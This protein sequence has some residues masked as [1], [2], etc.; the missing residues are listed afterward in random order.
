MTIL[1]RS[2]VPARSYPV[3]RGGLRGLRGEHVPIKSRTSETVLRLRLRAVF[4]PGG[5]WGPI[6]AH[7][8]AHGGPRPTR[9]PPGSQ[10]AARGHSGTRRIGHMGHLVHYLGGPSRGPKSPGERPRALYFSGLGA[11]D[12]RRSGPRPT[13]PGATGKRRG[14]GREARI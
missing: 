8:K 4:A 14:Y 5:P 10:H 11:A 7:F 6:I 3:E 2:I 1:L 13:H 12:A 9:P